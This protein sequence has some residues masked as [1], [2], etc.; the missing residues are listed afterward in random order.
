VSIFLVGISGEQVKIQTP[1]D[2]TDAPCSQSIVGEG[3]S[4]PLRGSFPNALVDQTDA[5]RDEPGHIANRSVG[6]IHAIVIEVSE[7]LCIGGCAH[8]SELI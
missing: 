1:L 2:G 5:Y 7:L 8:I 6:G 3:A 4:W